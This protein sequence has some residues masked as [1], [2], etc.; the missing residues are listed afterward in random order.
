MSEENE[1]EALRKEA[2]ELGVEVKHQWGIPKLT[3]EIAQ[4]KEA[5]AKP[6]SPPDGGNDELTEMKAMMA[7]LMKQNADLQTQLG[8]IQ[9][10][11]TDAVDEAALTK[12]GLLKQ[13]LALE[14][15]AKPSWSAT[16]LQ[17]AIEEAVSDIEDAADA[18]QA[19]YEQTTEFMK[20]RITKF[21]ANK[22]SMGKHTGGAGDMRAPED[23]ELKV[24]RRTA[25]GL[26]ARGF[27]EIIGPA[28]D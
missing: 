18:R 6:P 9:A 16:R 2:S 11:P 13:A 4:A 5:A 8:Q 15:N 7:Q 1:L 22:V 28:G 21:G 14:I 25:E 24:D 23:K 27:A 3:E 20:I 19:A 17:Q 12:E 10:Q 26:E